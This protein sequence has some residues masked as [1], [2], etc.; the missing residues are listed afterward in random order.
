[1][2]LITNDI[3]T[4]FK[5]LLP[6]LRGWNSTHDVFRDLI[7]R[8]DPATI[9]EVGTW[10]GA[11]AIH[12]A[13]ICRSTLRHTHIYCVD[14]WLGAPEFWTTLADTPERDLH[15]HHGYPQ[16]YYQF[17]SNVIHGGHT[18][19]ITPIP[20]TSVTGAKI[21]QHMGVQAELIYIDGSHEYE[22]VKADIRAYL[23]LLKPGGVMFGDDYSHFTDVARAV[24]EELP[25]HEVV[26]SNYW[27]YGKS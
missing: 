10:K 16:V 22:D 4:G 19:R 3:Y 11:S 9:I 17:I 8:T 20:N 25:R 23:P 12:M 24:Q 13:D 2:N 1:M 26:A 27:I 15:L 14:T 7:N 21:L 5:P 6:D 18:R